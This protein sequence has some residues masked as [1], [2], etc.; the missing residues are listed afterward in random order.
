MYAASMAGFD[1]FIAAPRQEKDRNGEWG[2]YSPEAKRWIPVV[3]PNKA[4][5][6]HMLDVL[7]HGVRR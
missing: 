7:Q 5:A 3:Y 4:A 2:L 1:N 6:E